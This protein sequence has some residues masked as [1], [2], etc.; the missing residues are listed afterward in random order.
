M[1]G[2]TSW[3]RNVPPPAEVRI[4]SIVLFLCICISFLKKKLR[5]SFVL[6]KCVFVTTTVQMD[7]MAQ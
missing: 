7:A 3:E 4:N 6:K 1:P 2:G 5:K